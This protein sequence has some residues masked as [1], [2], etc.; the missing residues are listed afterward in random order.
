MT[1]G[2]KVQYARCRDVDPPRGSCGRARRFALAEPLELGLFSPRPGPR[3]P[4]F[5]AAA[6]P[7]RRAGGEGWSVAAFLPCRGR[8]ELP[9]A[10]AGQAQKLPFG[11][12]LRDPSSPGGRVAPKRCDRARGQAPQIGAFKTS[13]V[14]SCRGWRG[15]SSTRPRSMPPACTRRGQ[16]PCAQGYRPAHEPPSRPLATGWTG[17]AEARQAG[18]RQAGIS[19]SGQQGGGGAGWRSPRGP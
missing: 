18:G 11:R 3:P 2:S 9:P 16:R 5:C 15:G 4:T 17:A 10:A 7:A 1:R 14:S 6:S 19:T 8:A 13:K 12:R